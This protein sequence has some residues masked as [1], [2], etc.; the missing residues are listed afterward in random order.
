[1]NLIKLLTNEWQEMTEKLWK[2]EF[3]DID[4]IKKLSRE[5][6]NIMHEYSN[7][8][9]VPKEMCELILE[10]RWFAWWVA[11]AECTPMHGLCQELGNI[12]TAVHCHLR[13]DD[14]KYNDIEFFLD[15]L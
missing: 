9:Y 15:K 2:C 11:D 7:K 5:T 8:D 4:E 10:M 14:E 12:V 1:M 3:I 13:G 6:F